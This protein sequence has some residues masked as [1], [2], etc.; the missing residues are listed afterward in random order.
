[1]KGERKREGKN[2]RREK[3]KMKGESKREKKNK[4]REKGKE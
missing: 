4:R 3:G 1:M 2:K